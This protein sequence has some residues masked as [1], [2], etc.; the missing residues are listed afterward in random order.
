MSIMASDD[1]TKVMATE[2]SGDGCF[3]SNQK[4]LEI[5]N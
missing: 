5:V 1:A 3:S 4:L 2:G